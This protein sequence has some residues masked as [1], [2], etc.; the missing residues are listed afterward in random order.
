MNAQWLIPRFESLHEFL[1][2]GGYGPY[3]WSAWG[4]TIV[5]LGLVWLQAR[6]EWRRARRDLAA[7]VASGEGR[8][9]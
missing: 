6:R 7:V 8:S 4:L 9:R 1:T 5:V 2:M 3:V